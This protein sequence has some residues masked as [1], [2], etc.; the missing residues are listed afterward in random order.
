M[1]PSGPATR[2]DRCGPISNLGG[3]AF[4]GDCPLEQPLADAEAPPQRNVDAGRYPSRM[5]I[6]FT[7]AYNISCFEA[8]C[9]P[10]TGIARTREAGMLDV[11]LF[12]WV[13][14]DVGPSLFQ[15]R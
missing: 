1:A 10:E 11:G 6:E 8:C 12:S 4:C 7:A 9:A 13:F 5:F 15:L 2:C 14:E 3:S